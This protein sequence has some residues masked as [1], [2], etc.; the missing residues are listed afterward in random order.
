[1]RSCNFPLRNQT[2]VL[3]IIAGIV[4]NY[5]GVER[6][7]VFSGLFSVLIHLSFWLYMLPIGHAIDFKQVRSHLKDIW[8]IVLI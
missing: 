8:E 7:P 4:L 1:M 3:G 6:P 5:T 2:P